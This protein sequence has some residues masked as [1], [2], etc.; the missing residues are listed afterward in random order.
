M[1]LCFVTSWLLGFCIAVCVLLTQM[2]G[3]SRSWQKPNNQIQW[4]DAPKQCRKQCLRVLMG[5]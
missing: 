2:H 5:R 4:L 1:C 3:A